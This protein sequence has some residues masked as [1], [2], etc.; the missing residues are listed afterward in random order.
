MR[1]APELPII[2]AGT[3]QYSERLDHIVRW[4]HHNLRTLLLQLQTTNIR[5]QYR[6]NLQNAQGVFVD[7]GSVCSP[8]GLQGRVKLPSQLWTVSTSGISGAIPLPPT[9]L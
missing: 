9:H 2:T 7:Y 8:S 5:G 6:R 1:T 4:T 3:R